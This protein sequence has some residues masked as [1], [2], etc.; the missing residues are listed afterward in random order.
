MDK[1]FS[2]LESYL[3]WPLSQKKIFITH[4]DTRTKIEMRLVLYL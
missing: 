1:G 2:T 4:S 3:V